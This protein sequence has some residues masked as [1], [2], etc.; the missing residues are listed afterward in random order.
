LIFIT[1]Q[2]KRSLIKTIIFGNIVI[3]IFLYITIAGWNSFL[4]F[5]GVPTIPNRQ[6]GTYLGNSIASTVEGIKTSSI[7]FGGTLIERYLTIVNVYRR[8][9][10][11]EFKQ[12]ISFLSGFQ[13]ELLAYRSY[14]Q[15]GNSNLFGLN[16]YEINGRSYNLLEYASIYEVLYLPPKWVNFAFVM[17]EKLSNFLF[18]FGYLINP[19][20]F[21]ALLVK[22]LRNKSHRYIVL[23][24]LSAT[25][26][27]N[28]I[29]HLFISPIDRYLFPGYPLILII[30]ISLCWYAFENLKSVIK[31]FA[32]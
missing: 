7:N 20:I 14:N 18:S 29:T 30:L 3:A 26:L 24:M 31:R 13:N 10:S 17:R 19:I 23:L 6:V 21:I 8:E 22:F 27:V 2:V 1:S 4:A 11:S 32:R 12:S 25:S 15:Y 9:E 16:Y 5:Q 28:S